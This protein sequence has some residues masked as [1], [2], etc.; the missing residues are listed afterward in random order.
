MKFL[1]LAFIL[2]DRKALDEAAIKALNSVRDRIAA[3]GCYA[4]FAEMNYFGLACLAQGSTLS[5]GDYSGELKRC[6]DF[7]MGDRGDAGMPNW[8]SATTLLFL[9][10]VQKKEP[11]EE[12]KARMHAL[13]NRLEE[14]QESSG[15]WCHHKGFVYNG[16]RGPIGDLGILTSLV[17]AALAD[18]KSTGCEV[19]AA[20]LDRALK[21][22]GTHSEGDG[23]IYGTNNPLPDWGNSRASMMVVGL[24]FL[25]NRNEL[26]SKGARGLATK[27]KGIDSAHSFRPIHFFNSAVGN[28]VTGQFGAFKAE[29]LARILAMREKD[30]SIWFKTTGGSEYER[31]SLGTNTIGTA[32]LALILQLEKGH[33]FRP[34]AGP[35]KRPQAE[36]P[37]NPFS[38]KKR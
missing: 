33:V 35:K 12:I 14:S 20:V 30:G 4:K 28:Y 1:I 34:P 38:Q 10:E 22:C 6:V 21:Y 7:A 24:H 16:R 19:P 18:A 27:V 26:Y 17:I 13:I 23:L 31:N 11:S 9:S 36:P 29:W 32:V 5:E 3:S 15:G 8:H 37:A 2:Q 25:N